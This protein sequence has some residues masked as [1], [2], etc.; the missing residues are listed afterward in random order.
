M[1]QFIFITLLSFTH[2]L[3]SQAQDLK[4][5]TVNIKN[6]DTTKKEFQS[7]C[8]RQNEKDGLIV[9][10]SAIDSLE[11]ESD[12]IDKVV[13]VRDHYNL[14][15]PANLEGV[16]IRIRRNGYDDLNWVSPVPLQQLEVRQY[17]IKNKKNEEKNNSIIMTGEYNI[18]TEPSEAT[19]KM[20]GFPDFSHITPYKLRDYRSGVYP[21]TFSKENYRDTTVE[22]SIDPSKSG[23]YDIKLSPKVGYLSISGNSDVNGAKILID[24]N[25]EFPYSTSKIELIQGR[26]S[27]IVKKDNFGT[28]SS[29]FS[30]S[31]NENK[32]INIQLYRTKRQIIKCS[33]TKARVII[34]DKY[35]GKTSKSGFN[36]DLMIGTHT[37]Q[38]SKDNF[39]TYYMTV[40]VVESSDPPII[41][42]NLEQENHKIH[43]TSRPSAD[44][45][46]DGKFEGT[47]PIT[48]STTRGLHVVKIKNREYFTN[49]VLKHVGSSDDNNVNKVL[50][51]KNLVNFNVMY[52]FETWG[53]ELGGMSGHFTWALEYINRPNSPNFDNTVSNDGTFD[54]NSSNMELTDRKYLLKDTAHS[55]SGGVLKLGVALL[56]PF[57]IRYHLGIMSRR[58]YYYNEVYRVTKTFNWTN[59]N[60]GATETSYQGDLLKGGDIKTEDHISY[61]AGIEVPLFHYVNLQADYWIN[62]EGNSSVVFGLGYNFFRSYARPVKRH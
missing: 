14:C 13:K 29:Y 28:Y 36:Y 24:E 10:I 38:I 47:S 43:V 8:P 48:L 5:L 23:T 35:V 57:P 39:V 21:I 33:E 31:E 52:G 25:K 56:K 49:S 59:S 11:F 19:I 51:P 12:D 34:D 55:T 16:S 54:Y 61:G 40:N 3:R 58:H 7:I 6:E 62:D 32:N 37:I 9:F 26:H 20:V 50:F 17:I 22:I 44:I 53:L 18:I 41:E 46:L 60:T 1:K 27:I 30:I 45:Y 4:E 42:C 2:I 15:I